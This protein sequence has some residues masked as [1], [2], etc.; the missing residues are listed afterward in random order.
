MGGKGG[1]TESKEMTVWRLCE[2][3]E[4]KGLLIKEGGKEKRRKVGK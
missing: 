1:F 3:I 4:R 2:K